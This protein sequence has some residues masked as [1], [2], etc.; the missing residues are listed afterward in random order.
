MSITSLTN[1]SLHDNENMNHHINIHTM[2]KIPKM[3]SGRS[4]SISSV[5]SIGS[6]VD[7]QN[8]KDHN[9][10]ANKNDRA[11]SA[12][13]A[14]GDLKLS[15]QEKK[16]RSMSLSQ[17]PSNQPNQNPKASSP[18][19]TLFKPL[20]VTSSKRQNSD[21]QPQT[22]GL[23]NRSHS[24]AEHKSNIPK[25]KRVDSDSI[26]YD[27][28][29]AMVRDRITLKADGFGLTDQSPST[30]GLSNTIK[31]TEYDQDRLMTMIKEAKTLSARAQYSFILLQKDKYEKGI[32]EVMNSCTRI[33]IT[34]QLSSVTNK[35]PLKFKRHIFF[36]LSDVSSVN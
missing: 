20:I 4:M 17:S 36:H 22:D 9:I 31:I 8:D 29:D 11:L 18:S 34:R 24:M 10:L 15:H 19:P 1:D 7:P 13:G 28:N 30:P 6:S 12:D 14:N 25:R 21:S 5:I 23:K 3:K 35:I 16:Q 32:A 33:V 27:D 2:G 26:G